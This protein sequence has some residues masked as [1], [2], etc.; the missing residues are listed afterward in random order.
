MLAEI[1]ISTAVYAMDKPYSYL[2]PEGM[3]LRPGMR[4]SVPFGRG[5]RMVEGMVLTLSPGTGEGL[6]TVAQALD[7]TPILSESMLRLAAFLR[8]RYFCTFYDAIRTIF[9]A[10]VWIST[11]DTYELPEL[12]EDWRYQIRRKPA[13]IPLLEH[14]QELG[15]R[16]EY[17]ALLRV[18]PD[19]DEL[20][21]LLRYLLGKKL[22]TSQTLLL[23]KSRD[24]TEKM[25]ALLVTNQEAAE[26]AAAHRKSAPM[27]AAVLEM[28]VTVGSCSMKELL[29]FTGANSQTVRRLS[30]LGLVQLWEA[31]VLRR[32]PAEPAQ[33]DVSY[34]LTEEQQTVFEGLNA[35]MQQ[36]SPGVA[37][38]Y[39]V[40]GSGKT[41]VYIQLIRTC[42]NK[43]KSAMLLVPEI[44][45]TP[46]LISLLTACFSQQVAV[47]HSSLRIGERYDE[48]KRIRRGEAKVILGVRSAV[49]APVEDLGLLILDEEQEHT[50]KS[51]NTPRYHAR[52]VAIYRGAR[53]GALVLLGSATP[54]VE[55]MYRAKQGIY[56]LFTL[57]HR[58]NGRDLPR[59]QLVDMKQEL[60]SGNEGIISSPLQAA[61]RKT[62]SAG[63]KSI[64]LLNRRGGARL[65]ICMD[66]GYVP[67]CPNCSANLTYHMMNGRL[68]CHY[69]GYS[70]PYTQRCT[71]C[72]GQCKQM[73][74]GT[75]RAQAELE[76]LLP[77]VPILR[78]DSD[79]VS[80]RN[81]H[82]K[83][84]SDFAKQAGAVLLGTQMVAKGLDF[85]DVT[86][87]GVLDAD[88]ALYVD[89]FRAAENTFSLVTQVIGRSGRGTRTGTAMIQTLTPGNSVLRLAAAQDYDAFYENEIS[90][91][92][93]RNC[94]PFKD[95]IEIGFVGFPEHH[96][97]QCAQ[98]FRSWLEQTAKA[99]GGRHETGWLL[100]PAPASVAKIN[101]RFYYRLTLRCENNRPLRQQLSA[102]LRQFAGDK[103][104]RGVTAFVNVNGYE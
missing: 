67:A 59:V 30:D 89:N 7:S 47:L 76:E 79:T 52:E 72:G 56:S 20:Q 90:L 21:E 75:Q 63:Q 91:R 82:E 70:E 94:P 18:I 8:E 88:Q 53:S 4:V 101:N 73:G 33:R 11:Q 31:E 58:F 50:Y 39:G 64:L 14:L 38:L 60:R 85:A 96:V 15:G 1:A 22:L 3:E 86:L 43:G 25:A 5:N 80:P 44:A 36:E 103:Q 12:P 9:P 6:K 23:Q 83:V 40:T 55:T 104:T 42:L 32:K 57:S 2:V 99:S 13:A 10:G 81:T 48:W 28:L 37:L 68:M 29:Y 24:K 17:R 78:M 100:G 41:A 77:E 27:Q 51:E 54:S 74:S 65:T 45:L 26:Y 61:I 93:A 69:C 62:S 49:F 97:K 71:A 16:A 46:Q 35:Q 102:L 92:R 95:L 98:L 34:T 19:A 84:L 87:V 66:C